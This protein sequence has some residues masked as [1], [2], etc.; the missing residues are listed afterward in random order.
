[1]YDYEILMWILGGE[2]AVAVAI[3]ACSKGARDW[4]WG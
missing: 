1:M 4:L 3:L 2:L